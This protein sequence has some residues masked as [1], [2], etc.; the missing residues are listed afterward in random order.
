VGVGTAFSVYIPFLDHGS[1]P[2]G[3][4]RQTSTRASIPVDRNLG[5]I[6]IVDDEASVRK[7]ANLSLKRKGFRVA[8]AEDGPPAIEYFKAHRDSIEMI[9]L[10]RNM[11]L[12]QGEE[13]FRE[14]IAIDPDVKVV[15]CSGFLVDLN[16]F[17]TPGGQI[18]TDFLQKPYPLNELI[19]KVTSAIGD[20]VALPG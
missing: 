14:L 17:A 8:E 7:I 4:V 13:V 10:D 1:A 16:E 2:S 3:E 20:E 5:E 15:V 19:D 12:M 18:P 9:L 11:P 6:L